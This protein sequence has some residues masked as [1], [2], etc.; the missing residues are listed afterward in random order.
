MSYFLRLNSKSSSS[1]QAQNKARSIP[2]HT[3]DTAANFFGC[4]DERAKFG[5]AAVFQK[6]F[7]K[8]TPR[9]PWRRGREST[10][11]PRL[12]D[13]AFGAPGLSLGAS[14]S[15]FNLWQSFFKPFLSE[16][17]KSEK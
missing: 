6:A 3:G 7:T 14:N 8:S 10:R 15:N 4:C 1:A 2:I 16:T 12:Q 5:S 13:S 11:R 17:A 9:W